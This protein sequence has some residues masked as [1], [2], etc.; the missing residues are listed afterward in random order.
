MTIFLVVLICVVFI[1]VFQIVLAAIFYDFAINTRKDRTKQLEKSKNQVL[2][3]E[4][5]L[6]EKE[7]LKRAK[8]VYIKSN[9]GLKLHA[10]ELKSKE[11]KDWIILAHGYFG[12]GVQM[13][14]YAFNLI[15]KYNLLLIELRGHGKSE[16]NYADFGVKSRHDILNWISYINELYGNPKLGL[17]GVSMGASS[18]MMTT[19]FTIPSNV[20]FIIE[21]SGFTSAKEELKYQLR[22]I[23]HLPSFP[24]LLLANSYI[25]MKHGF[26]IDDGSAIHAISYNKIPILFIH[27]G[28]DKLVPPYM[29]EKLFSKDK[30]KKE[31]IIIENACHASSLYTN[32][33]L[34]LNTV[35]QFIESNM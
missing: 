35:Y 18:I 24:T 2:I 15:G 17:Y 23:Y 29:M 31:K 12:N 28:S 3:P 14:P 27:G 19:N 34:Y 8:D 13:I 10:L 6:E 4:L 5:T 21:D 16:G 33:E 9:D 1:S 20:K 30:G 32:K 25:K 7:L 11:N 22:K 26:T